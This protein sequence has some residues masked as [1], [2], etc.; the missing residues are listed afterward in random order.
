MAGTLKCVGRD[1]HG[2]VQIVEASFVFPVMFMILFF[3]I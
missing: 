3:L 1:E 2:A